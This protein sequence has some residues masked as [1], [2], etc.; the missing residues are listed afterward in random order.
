MGGINFDIFY[1][2]QHTQNIISIYNH[3]NMIKVF[4]FFPIQN[5]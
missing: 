4:H 2:T 3:K 1:L 5:L